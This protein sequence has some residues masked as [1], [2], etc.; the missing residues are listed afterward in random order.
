MKKHLLE[1]IVVIFMVI[2]VI[3]IAFDFINKYEI[4]KILKI[5]NMNDFSVQELKGLSG[6]G[7]PKPI[8]IKFKISFNKYKEYNLQYQDV[9]SDDYIYEGEITNKKQKISDNYYMCYYESVIYDD[10]EKEQ[11]R[12]MI[13]NRFFLKVNSTISIFLLFVY[14]IRKMKNIINQKVDYRKNGGNKQCS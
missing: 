12:G 8:F 13:N 5:D 4:S 14:V 9:V 2:E 6:Y 10:K 1:I 11:F 7:S 3:L